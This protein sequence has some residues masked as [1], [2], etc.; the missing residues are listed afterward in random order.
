MVGVQEGSVLLFSR[1]ELL[2]RLSVEW[3]GE[4]RGKNRR[5][6]RCQAQRI[7][8]ALARTRTICD[9]SRDRMLVMLQ[10]EALIPPI[11]S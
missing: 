3:G 5:L 10:L 11:V 6:H 7:K 1:I 8:G 9:N 2:L 4:E